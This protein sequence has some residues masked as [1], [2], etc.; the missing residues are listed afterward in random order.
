MANNP[1]RPPHRLYELAVDADAATERHTFCRA[2]REP[3]EPMALV[4]L[5]EP[6]GDAMVTWVT[7]WPECLI[8]EMDSR[9]AHFSGVLPLPRWK[10]NVP[11]NLEQLG[12]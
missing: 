4:F 2:T 10:L 7:R 8:R 3:M 5:D 9:G 1:V 11:D 6:D 12:G